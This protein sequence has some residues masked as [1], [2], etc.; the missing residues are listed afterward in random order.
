M[1]GGNTSLNFKDHALIGHGTMA[2]NSKINPIGVVINLFDELSNGDNRDALS[3][4][5][6]QELGEA[7]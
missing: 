4:A 7:K 1:I 2:R 5:H 3:L 6:L